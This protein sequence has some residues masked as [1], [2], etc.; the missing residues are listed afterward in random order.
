MTEGP[1]I[2]LK[3]ISLTWGRAKSLG[4]FSQRL[5]TLAR[6]TYNHSSESEVEARFRYTGFQFHIRRQLSIFVLEV[7]K[8]AYSAGEPGSF[9]TASR[10]VI[11]TCDRE[12]F[13]KL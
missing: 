5:G 10:V 8:M 11:S 7:E 12:V 6:C 1:Q 3:V 4:E 2:S 9:P 13:M